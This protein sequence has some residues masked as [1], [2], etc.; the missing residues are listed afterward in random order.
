MQVTRELEVSEHV[1]LAPL[2]S[3]GVGGPARYFV[4]ACSEAELLLALEWAERQRVP[5]WLLGGGSN[6]V[7]SDAGVNGLVVRVATRGISV[8]KRGPIAY[9]S[10]AAGE[11][12]DDV[13][14]QAV[15][16][17]LAGIENMSGVPGLVGA[18]PIQNVGA[19]GQEVSDTIVSVRAFDRESSSVTQLSKQDCRFAYRSSWFKRGARG[20][21]VI[22]G[23]TYQLQTAGPPNVGYR[24]LAQA[25]QASGITDPTLEDVRTA[26]LAVRRSKSML[27]DEADPDA[28]SCGSFFMN[29]LVSS[30]ELDA[31]R[32]RAG[33]N[34]LPCYPQSD[35]RVK[36]PAAWLIERAGLRKGEQLGTAA[37]SSRHSLALVCRSECRAADVVALARRVRSEVRRAFDV[38]LMPEPEF[39]GFASLDQGLPDERL[40]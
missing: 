25:L 19:Y 18:T 8:E 4:D 38:T 39:W 22:L 5:F 10:A 33:T 6:V 30:A 32:A 24:D 15:A 35:G 2:T 34:D 1:S 31:V 29:P 28:Q 16:R 26:V 37:I 17:R 3:L 13:V 40:A 27:L 23:V 21:F 36:L 11:P 7:I 14:R 9:V 20:R 12:W